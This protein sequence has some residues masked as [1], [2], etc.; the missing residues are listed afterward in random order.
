MTVITWYHCFRRNECCFTLL[1]ITWMFPLNPIL[2]TLIPKVYRPPPVM[3]KACLLE[4]Q[5]DTHSQNPLLLCSA[6]EGDPECFLNAKSLPIHSEPCRSL[7][8]GLFQE[9]CSLS[10]QVSN[11]LLSG[12]SYYIHGI[13]PWQPTLWLLSNKKYNIRTFICSS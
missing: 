12:P 9:V 2:W 10:L 7:T 5:R 6:S 13:Y 1:K 8:S 4:L 11:L 3:P